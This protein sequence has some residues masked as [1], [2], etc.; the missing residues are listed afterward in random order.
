MAG[1]RLNFVQWSVLALAA[2]AWGCSGGSDKWTEARPQVYP[3]GGIVQY[4][5]APLEGA[6]VVFRSEAE[7]KAAYGTTNAEGKFTLTTFEEGDG[8]VAGKHQVRITKIKTEIA[9]APADPG[10]D[11][12]PPKETSLLPAKYAD[13]KTSGLTTEVA[14]GGENQFEFTL[15][16]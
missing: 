11:V 14:P 7:Q 5:G 6:T 13:F 10:A 1:K 12:V 4:N 16:D 15:Q 9:P 2:C 3:A 8:A